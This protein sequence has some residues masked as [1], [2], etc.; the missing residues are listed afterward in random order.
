[1]VIFGRPKNL[2][3]YICVDSNTSKKLH[4]LGFQPNHRF[5][6]EIYFTKTDEIVE[7]MKT[8]NLKTK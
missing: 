6:G 5:L 3:S 7:V 2:K 8:W 1:M 4:E